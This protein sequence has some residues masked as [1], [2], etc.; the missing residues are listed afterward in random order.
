MKAIARFAAHRGKDWKPRHAAVLGCL[1]A[2]RNRRTNLCRPGNPVI[3][4]H[5]GISE[6]TVERVIDE[7]EEWGA[8]TK[9]KLRA[10]SSGRFGPLQYTFLFSLPHDTQVSGGPHDKK[11]GHHTTKNEVTMRQNQGCNKEEAKDLKPESSGASNNPAPDLPNAALARGLLERIQLPITLQNVTSVAFAIEAI[12]KQYGL[13]NGRACDWLEHQVWV[14]RAT[15]AQINRFWFEDANYNL[16]EGRKQNANDRLRARLERELEISNQAAG[17][18]LR[19][20][21]THA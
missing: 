19:R 6:R 12:E 9:E 4:A 18:V 5:C 1:L 14:A 16:P 11:P 2:H 3:A 8:F 15:G 10:V 21:G 17:H 13:P 7:L 20:N